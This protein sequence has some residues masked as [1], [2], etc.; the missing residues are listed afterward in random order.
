M[1]LDNLRWGLV[2]KISIDEVLAGKPDHSSSTLE[3]IANAWTDEK[4]I[5]CSIF[6][7]ELKSYCVSLDQARLQTGDFTVMI[8]Y[9]CV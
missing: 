3:G 2:L 5:N 6:V 8:I 9:T 1:V 4:D 7:Q